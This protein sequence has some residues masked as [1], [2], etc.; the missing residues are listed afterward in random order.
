MKALLNKYIYKTDKE[1]Y[2]CSLKKI[3]KEVKKCLDIEDK[4]Y[5]CTDIKNHV[6]GNQQTGGTQR[7]N[8]MIELIYDSK[9]KYDKIIKYM[10]Y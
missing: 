6:D 4:C 1:F 7:N 9:E 8:I 5:K 2:K 3:L 10:Y